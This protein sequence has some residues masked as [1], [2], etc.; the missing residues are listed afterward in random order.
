MDVILPRVYAGSADNAGDGDPLRVLADA[1]N[2]AMERLEAMVAR[3]DNLY[4]END[5]PDVG[6]YDTDG[7]TDECNHAIGANGGYFGW[8]VTSGDGATTNRGVTTEYSGAVPVRTFFHIN[9]ADRDSDVPFQFVGRS[10]AITGGLTYDEFG[11]APGFMT[12]RA[13]GTFDSPT[14]ALSGDTLG[15]LTAKGRQS[16]GSYPSVSPVGFIFVATEDQTG[17]AN[18]S[19]IDCYSTSVGS[20]SRTRVASFNGGAFIVSSTAAVATS[21][22]GSA[23]TPRFQI[24]RDDAAGQLIGAFSSTNIGPSLYLARSANNTVGSH[25]VV[26]A[27]DVLGQISAAGSDGSAFAEGAKILFLAAGAPSSSYTPGIIRFQTSPGGSATVA[28]WEIREDGELRRSTS[29]FV[30]ASG[31]VRFRIYT[32]QTLPTATSANLGFAVVSNPESGKTRQVENVSS[33]WVYAGDGS[34]VSLV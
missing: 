7:P 13:G 22:S 8:R 27:G 3:R 15:Y 5:A 24:L 12:R 2:E 17:S 23:I 26:A 21:V 16:N 4:V 19:R 6:F 28:R 31:H 33:V 32:R 30:D 34:T 14:A 11:K 29:P 9:T 25:T 18:G 1:F 10:T 20:T